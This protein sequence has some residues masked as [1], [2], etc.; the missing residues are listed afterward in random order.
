MPTD[1]GPREQAHH[2]LDQLGPSQ[3]D[4]IVHLLETMILPMD[5]NDTLS[6]AD[7]AAI[8]EAD[9]WLTHNEPISNEEVLADF[10]LTLA[11]WEKMGQE[12]LPEERPRRNG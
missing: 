5:E 9:R 11:D 7:R 1:M 10:G 6:A 2:L 4:A 3:L 8:A 12:P